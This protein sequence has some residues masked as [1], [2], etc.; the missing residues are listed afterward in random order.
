MR[1][2]DYQ[3]R[4][5]DLVRQGRSIILQAPTGAG[6]TF[7]S[8]WPFYTGWAASESKMPQKCVYAVPMR[9]LANQFEEEV[10]RLVTEEM[11]FKSPPMVKKQ[12]GEYKQDPEFR[13]DI[14]F[15]TIDQV[16]SSWLMAPYSL[17][18]RLGN[19]NAGAFVGSYLIFDEFHLFDPDS[20]LPTTLQMLKTLNSISPFV[21]MTA[22]FSKEMLE[23]LA[24]HLNAKA[25]LLTD[26]ML[27]EI[28]AQEKDRRFYTAAVSM[29]FKDENKQV[30]AA[31]KAVSHILQTHQ[32]QTIDK[33]RTLVVCN[34]VERAQAVF[35]ALRDQKP[36]G[37]TVCLLHSRYLKEDRQKIED[38][39]RQEFNKDKEQQ[40]IPSLIVVATQVVEVGLDMSCVVLHTDLAPA[41]SVLQR[42]GRCARY[43]G[44]TGQVYVYPLDEKG[45]APYHGRHARQECLLAWE[46][47]QVN[48]DRHLTFADEQALINYAHAASDN[49][50]LSAV[51]G[52]EYER[53]E[54]I[55]KAWEGKK[56]RGETAVL[57][58]NIQSV[59]VAVHS[60]P[61][62]LAAGPFKAESFSLHPGT[63]QGKFAQWQAKNDALDPDIDEGYLDWLVCKLVEDVEDEEDIQGNRPI[64]Y[65]FKIVSSRHDLHAPLLVVNPALVGYSSE[66][67]LTLYPSEQYECDVPETAVA[68]QYTPY[69]Y[70]LESY[71][72]HIELVHQAFVNE[73]LSLFNVAARRLEKAYEW[74]EGI[75][76][77]MAHLVMAVHDV[78]KLSQGWQAWAQTWQKAIGQSE[79]DFPTAHT[80]YDPTNPRHQIKVGKRPSHAVESA[81]ASLPIMQKLIISDMEKYRPLLR[82]AFTAVARHHAPFSSQPG[83]YRLIPTHMQEIENTL[84]LLPNSVQQLCQDIEAH[85]NTDAQKDLPTDFIERYLLINS[86][87]ERDVCCYMLLVRALRTADQI[88]TKLGSL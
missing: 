65:G 6:K 54:Q 55:W 15:A 23:K 12:T 10:K 46:W 38:F 60:D 22:T 2:Y 82:A 8:L 3:N 52:T 35:T 14:T 41:A 5:A 72:R 43:P 49:M 58:R 77:E 13:A 37:V 81:L 80:D 28:P 40:S 73:S 24:N 68:Q 34:Q 7:A 86:R 39:I 9:V 87:N 61:D 17:P 45:Y 27:A 42:A 78:G 53:Q 70:K 16:L 74:C 67:G 63:L 11:R 19:M 59:S 75:I 57:I 56:D 21:L 20:T 29:T 44:E 4:L 84:H 33:P 30:R 18:R 32:N 48:Q 64:R 69:S 1:T 47:L 31:E 85:A 71:Y 79:L 51:F 66:L 83:S 36:D 62:Q 26:E 50:I 88:G 76:T 25:F